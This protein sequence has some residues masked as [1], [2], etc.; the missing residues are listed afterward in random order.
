MQDQKHTEGFV[1]MLVASL[2]GIRS[3]ELV[4]WSKAD[5]TQVERLRKILARAEDPSNFAAERANA[6]RVLQALLSSMG[7]SQA[8]LRKVTSAFHPGVDATVPTF[9]KLS[10]AKKVT[11]RRAWFETF[12]SEIATP[13]GVALGLPRS[14][15]PYGRQG[16][17]GRAL[18]GPP[19]AVV[20]ASVVIAKVAECAMK[21][22]R[23]HDEDSYCAAFCKQCVPTDE[24]TKAA[25]K[26]QLRSSRAVKKS[27]GYTST[28]K[29]TPRSFKTTTPTAESGR[30]AGRKRA[31]DFE[32]DMNVVKKHHMK[33]LT[34]C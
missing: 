25:R 8:D 31:C 32:A 20:L 15:G 26:L 33:A 18:F 2:G 5:L 4:G 3:E 28:V 27:F 34:D 14:R 23:K 11:T 29:S 9:A 19:A 22:C 30:K 21:S 6:G 13:L 1:R 16:H 7:K 10:F 12:S 24:S 17:N